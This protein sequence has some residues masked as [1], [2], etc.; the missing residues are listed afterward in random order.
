[1][2]ANWQHS[3]RAASCDAGALREFILVPNSLHPHRESLPPWTSHWLVSR[4]VLF[5]MT[6]GYGHPEELWQGARA[7]KVRG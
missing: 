4:Q 6:R 1:M 5:R 7:T 3:L 2:N